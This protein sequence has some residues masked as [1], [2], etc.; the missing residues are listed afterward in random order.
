MKVVVD[1]TSFW[2]GTSGPCKKAIKE[3]E[4]YFINV[5]TIEQLIELI[6]EVKYPLI[7]SR[8][9][10]ERSEYKIEIYDDYRE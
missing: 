4:D 2:Y 6:E 10:L 9:L 1:R 7:I 3:G 5:D 8:D